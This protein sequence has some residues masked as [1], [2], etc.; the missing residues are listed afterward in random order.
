VTGISESL[1]KKK[2]LL[3]VA[4][5]GIG[6]EVNAEKPKYMSMSLKNNVEKIWSLK[7][8][9]YLGTTITNQNYIHEQNETELG[10]Y[11]LPF[12]PQ[13]SVFHLASQKHEN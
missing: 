7:T 13:S 1:S 8:F 12:G 5:K 9:K 11:L 10:Q 4:S 3:L 2:T 6:L